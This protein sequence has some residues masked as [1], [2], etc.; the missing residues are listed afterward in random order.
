MI[1]KENHFMLI[2]SHDFLILRQEWVV[3]G[4]TRQANNSNTQIVQKDLDDVWNRACEVI[5]SLK[6]ILVI[7]KNCNLSGFNG[8]FI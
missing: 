3:V 7:Y 2:L 1:H 5:P 8:A 6:V 4:G